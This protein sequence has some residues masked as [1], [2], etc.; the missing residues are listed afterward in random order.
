MNTTAQWLAVLA[1]VIVAAGGGYWVGHHGSTKSSA[2]GDE[3]TTQP[4]EDKPVASVK[5]SPIRQD[6]M[7]AKIV[8]Y[9]PVTAQPSD[10]TVV[11]VPFESR[12]GRL[13]VTPGQE[14]AAGDV[15]GDIGPSAD[16]QLQ[17]KQAEAALAAAKKDLAQTQQRFTDHLATNQDLLLAQQNVESA[18]LKLESFDKN[19]A[20]GQQKLKATAAGIVSKVD[21]QEGQV[22]PVGGPLV[23]IAAGNRIVARLGIEPSDAPAIHKGDK[24]SLFS[25]A[26]DSSAAI[27]GTVDLITR[28]VN[29]D[30]RLVDIFVTLPPASGLMLESYVRGELTTASAQGLIVPREAV[31]PD[32]EGLT[33]FT[34]KDGHAVKH[35][36]T[37]SLRNE[38]DVLVTG[39]GLKAGDSAVVLGNL[40][41]EDAMPVEAA[42]A[43]E[44]AA[45][46]TEPTSQST[47]E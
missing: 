16:T 31:L 17:I 46:A 28:R 40:E 24:V 38:H 47:K 6:T 22:V 42:A 10:I 8:A 41:L 3:A 43:E 39:D 36:V 32:D 27:E 35:T 5:T 18:Q 23:E 14:V 25:I 15:L 20:A 21:V 19:G 11:S 30:T 7:A 9:G 37:V 45:P 13:V 4:D 44:T 12:V 26:D 34:V 29:P 33:L 2:G 1:L